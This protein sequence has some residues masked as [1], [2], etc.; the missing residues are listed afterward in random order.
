[1]KIVT[2]WNFFRVSSQCFHPSRQATS[3]YPSPL[4]IFMLNFNLPFPH[5]LNWTLPSL[6]RPH[7]WRDGNTIHTRKKFKFMKVSG[8]TQYR[9]HHSCHPLRHPHHQHLAYICI[10]GKRT[11]ARVWE[12][13]PGSIWFWWKF[14]GKNLRSE[15]WKEV[16]NTRKS[17]SR[18][19][20]IIFLSIFPTA[21]SPVRHSQSS[22]ASLSPPAIS[23]RDWW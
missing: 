6:L 5:L 1:M 22:A 8:W 2:L 11:T 3:S 10:G 13:R 18:F 12:T 9:H 14:I 7:V 21:A 17:L 19:K 23:M 16:K 15:R 20:N 4:P